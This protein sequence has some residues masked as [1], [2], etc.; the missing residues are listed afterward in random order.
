MAELIER[1]PAPRQVLDQIPADSETV[2]AR[3]ALLTSQ[4]DV[5]EGQLLF[6]GDHDLTS[7]AYA[8]ARPGSE[9]TV[10][11]I[12]E[13]LLEFID[14]V[15]RERGLSIRV[16]FADLRGGLPDALAGSAALVFTDPPYSPDGVALFLECGL[17][18]LANRDRGRVVFAYGAG[19]HRP[20]LALAVQE[21]LQ[22]LRVVI[23]AMYPSFNRYVLA[24]AIGGWS[25]LYVCRPTAAT[26]RRLGRELPTRNL[27]TQG[28]RAREARTDVHSPTVDAAAALVPNGEVL[29]LR[30]EPDELLL[31]ALLAANGPVAVVV[32]NNHRD[33]V[34]E[35]SQRA[36]LALVEPRCTVRFHRSTPDPSTAVVVLQAV[37]SAP[38][39]DLAHVPRHRL[40]DAAD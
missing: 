9:I 33:I 10:V 39:G 8:R 27:Y 35:R 13:P 11:D 22:R 38:R 7:I 23:E 16:L 12:D 1:A 26:W 20:D 34:D 36:F 32:R 18:A 17:A 24:Q 21:R 40:T 31:R 3:V 25:D 15:A 6:L 2:V 14:G 28:P 30:R 29:D 5:G 19:D 37:G 4:F